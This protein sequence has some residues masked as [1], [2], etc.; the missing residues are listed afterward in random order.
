[1][2]F[3]SSRWLTQITRPASQI[4]TGRSTH[5]TT[6]PQH[7]QEATVQLSHDP[8]KRSILTSLSP[9]VLLAGALLGVQQE[10]VHAQRR[11]A[12]CAQPTPQA[13][14]PCANVLDGTEHMHLLMRACVEL[15]GEQL[16][17]T[18]IMGSAH[19]CSS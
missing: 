13:L 8:R 5:P 15:G 6:L 10:S 12:R 17:C 1:M 3:L 19:L 16:A 18:H 11:L 4:L 9:Q 14:T 7:K 2:R